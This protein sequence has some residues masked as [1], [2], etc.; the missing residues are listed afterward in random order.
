MTYSHLVKFIAMVFVDW[1][2]DFQ[3]VLAAEGM[4]T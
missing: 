2:V 1:L 3:E 4:I